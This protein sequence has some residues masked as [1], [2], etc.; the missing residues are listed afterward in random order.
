MECHPVGHAIEALRYSLGYHRAD[1]SLRIAVLLAHNTPTELAGLC[2][3]IE[4]VHP[5]ALPAE[6][7]EEPYLVR[8]LAHVPRQWDWIVDNPRRRVTDRRADR[9]PGRPGALLP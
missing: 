3:F 5:V 6:L 8:A 7:A 9:L 4:A 2:P 1:P